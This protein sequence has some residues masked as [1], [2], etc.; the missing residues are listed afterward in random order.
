MDGWKIGV[1]IFAALT[2]LFVGIAAVRGGK[3]AHQVTR[4]AIS[5]LGALGLVHLLGA[6]SG[7]GLGV[8]WF[9]GGTACLLGV[10]GVVT[11]L[12]LNIILQ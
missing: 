6:F 8:G 2:A 12:L 10:P 11:L 5:G 3:P 4:S 7:I 1:I 9:T